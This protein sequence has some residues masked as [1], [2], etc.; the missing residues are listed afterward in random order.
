[1]QHVVIVISQQYVHSVRWDTMEAHVKEPVVN[2]VLMT[3]EKLME[4]VMDS[5]TIDMAINVAT[6][7]PVT[8]YVGRIQ[9]AMYAR[10]DGMVKP[11]CQHATVDVKEDHVSRQMGHV[12][13]RLVGMETSVSINVGPTVRHVTNSKGVHS[14]IMDIMVNPVT[15]SA[16]VDV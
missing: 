16:A 15:L 7:V 6:S 10:L 1:M 8:V 12:H 13:V 2:I 9:C 5:R 14:V 3:A 4:N 11:V